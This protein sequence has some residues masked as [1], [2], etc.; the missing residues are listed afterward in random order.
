MVLFPEKIF[1]ALI[2]RLLVAKNQKICSVGKSRKR[3]E[4]GVFFEKKPFSSFHKPSL[5]K[6]EAANY[7]GSGRG[8]LVM[9]SSKQNYKFL[10]A[11]SE[12]LRRNWKPK[13]QQMES[14]GKNH[15][16]K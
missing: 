8:R 10:I 1:S 15:F 2:M 14:L 9:I 6:W 7:A 4:E 3:D 11:F 16:E 5:Q 13:P 12:I